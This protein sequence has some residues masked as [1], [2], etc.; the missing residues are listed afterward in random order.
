MRGERCGGIFFKKT[1]P[2]FASRATFEAAFEAVA[3]VFAA[4]QAAIAASPASSAT[5]SSAVA[6]S[7]RMSSA[8][9][10]VENHDDWSAGTCRLNRSVVVPTITTALS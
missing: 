6:S 2:L 4:L 1:D 8:R 9:S 10:L 3:R 5:S 7:R